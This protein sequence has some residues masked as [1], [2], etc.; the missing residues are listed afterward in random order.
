MTTRRKRGAAKATTKAGA[1]IATKAARQD[2]GEPAAAHRGPQLALASNCAV[3]DSA[4]LKQ[5]LCALL[6]EP[7]TIT[8]DVRALERIDTAAMQLLCAFARER[9]GKG[10]PTAWMGDVTIVREAAAILDVEPMLSLP[11]VDAPVLAEPAMVEPAMV[12]ATG[13]LT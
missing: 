7:A 2:A 10:Y 9:A 5:S 4:G 3:K 8:L 12:S 13:A 11:P 6:G 1:D